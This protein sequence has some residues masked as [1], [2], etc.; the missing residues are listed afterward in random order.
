M[1]HSESDTDS[2]QG[3]APQTGTLS[4]LLEQLTLSV[5]QRPGTSLLVVG[6]VTLLCVAVTAR[7][8]SFKTNRS[9]L[10]NSKSEFHQRWLNYTEEF[11]DEAEVV[12]VVKADDQ[13]KIKNVIDEI[14]AIL[15]QEPE[16]FDRVLYRIDPGAIQSKLLQ[17]LPP[18]MLDQANS[19]LEM[20]APILEGHWSRAGIESYAIRINDY[21]QRTAETGSPEDL[22]SALQQAARLCNSLQMF[23]E[24]PSQFESPWPEIIPSSSL[25]NEN[26][27]E[28]RYQLTPTG[29]MG[30]ILVTPT[31]T[32]TDFSGG[33][34]SLSR[35][36]DIIH[37]VETEHADDDISIGMTGIPVLEADEMARSQKD[38]T[39]A[40][41][42]SF[43][44]V[45]LIML[46]GFRGFRHP[47]LA[48]AML[49][50][51]LAWSL[52]FTTL[53]VG[54]L[55]ILSVSFAAILIG[56]GIDFAIHYLAR[57]LELRHQNEEFHRSLALTSQSVG[58]GI[59]TAATTTAMAFFCATFTNFLGVAELGIIA[60]GGILLCGLATFTVLPPLVTLA[61]RNKETRQLPTPFQGNLLRKLIRERAGF[62]AFITIAAMIAI[63]VQGL[64]FKEGSIT[65]KVKYD[66][67]LLNLQAEGLE[68]VSLQKEIFNETSGSLLYAVSL[69][70]SISEVRILKEEF[71]QLP[72]VSR[73]EE[74]ASY[75]PPYPPEETNL[76]VQ[77]MH[78]RLSRLSD[79]PREF[80]Q[81]DP[82]SIG[83][84][85]ERLYE[86]LAQRSEPTAANA[87]GKLDAF[88]DRLTAMELPNQLQILSAYQGAM[89]TSLHRQFQALE[90]ISNPD[91]V[92]PNDFI[93]GIRERFVSGSGN[94]LL[95]VYPNEQIW[96][97][98]P[99][100]AFVADVRSVDPEATGTPLQNLEAARQIR[101]SYFDAA[102]YALLVIFLILLIDGLE[103]TALIVS[104]LA[105]LA[106]IAFAYSL[107][108]GVLT[109]GTPIQFAILYITVVALVALVFDSAS[110]RNTF[111]TL[112]PPLGGGFLMFGLLGIFKIDFNPAN[113]IVLPLILGIGVDDGVHV[114]HDYRHSLGRYETS[115][116][117][118]NAITLT[119]LTS[120]VGFGSMVVAAHQ[121]LVS[122]GMVL[123]IGVGSCLFVSLV[124]LPAILTLIDHRN[125][126]QPITDESA[127]SPEEESE[128]MT[129]PLQSRGPGVA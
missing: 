95:R 101:E 47:F 39:K 51:G 55:N 109:T 26:R 113:L 105:P 80:P 123:V 69:A 22:Q 23:T 13:L 106:V 57:Y 92:T 108:D 1:N 7:F 117:T 28:S 48:L 114:I 71:L 36:R 27:F 32:S 5:S 85:M 24:T 107:R 70:E 75:M 99:L 64:E 63:G 89:L 93:A 86:T 129:I 53:V 49:S 14:G 110:V 98:A 68:S 35:L 18:R 6:V 42:I 2:T 118:I 50:V 11:G 91:P 60:G 52:G 103:P 40:S 15:D 115:A 82:L 77:A 78:A 126:K 94:W 81:L 121:G 73:V 45:G 87:A 124:T 90:E 44:G 21:I 9:D 104:L 111:L 67:N 62:V 25:G 102:I 16:L 17:F 119:S 79:L 72:T 74:M 10:L 19:R 34:R 116:S 76:L 120:M 33:A 125:N 20:F 30:F 31:N 46:I 88:L 127:G 65:S 4:R 122:L 56:L 112:L 97:E 37:A 128:P 3:V 59:V 84:A 58:T 8:L 83:K 96:E 38:M 41:I 43:V 100:E 66:S 29:K 54:H 61:D 12:V